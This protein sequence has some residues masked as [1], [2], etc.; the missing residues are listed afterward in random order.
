MALRASRQPGDQLIEEGAT[1]GGQ[2]QAAAPVC[3]LAGQFGPD[4]GGGPGDEDGL[5]S[6][7]HGYG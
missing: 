7:F 3:E 1:P 5:L 4:S 2:Q 6:Q